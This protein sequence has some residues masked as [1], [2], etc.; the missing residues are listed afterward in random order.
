MT[1]APNTTTPVTP[2]GQGSGIGD[3][4]GFHLQL[5]QGAVCRHFADCLEELRLTQKQLLALWL[6]AEYP[7]LAQTGLGQHMHMDRASTMAIVNRLQARGFVV[8]GKSAADGRKQSL[9]ISQAGAA[10]L[11]KARQAMAEHEGWLKARYT[12]KEVAVLIELLMRLHG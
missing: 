3:M 7:G 11:A 6:V 12:A 8:R 5:A 9:H 2:L 10:A 1:T 4:V